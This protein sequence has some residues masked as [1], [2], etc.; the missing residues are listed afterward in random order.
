MNLILL[1]TEDARQSLAAGTP[2]AKHLREVLKARQGSTFWCGA[3]NGARGLATVETACPDGGFVFSVAWERGVPAN[4][5]S[6]P[7]LLLVGLSRPQT[8]KKIFAAAG[9]I[10]CREIRVFVTENGDPAYAQSSLWRD[11]NDELRAVLR[12]AAEQ[13]CTTFLPP[14]RLFPS[15]AD[16]CA[17]FAE[18][19]AGTAFALDVYEAEN[20]LADIDF[21]PLPA[22]TTRAFAIGSERGWTNAERRTL[23]ERGFIFAHLGSRVLRTETAAAVALAVAAARSGTWTRHTPVRG[24]ATSR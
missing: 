6:P 24:T 5:F 3:E 21:P 9:E 10:G 23:R 1:E 2:A 7:T 11:G 22:G 13:T 12:K 14:A 15:L 18:N 4:A 17:D 20:S 19:P 8:M 16:A